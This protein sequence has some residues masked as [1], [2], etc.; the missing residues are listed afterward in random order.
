MNGSL[1]PDLAAMDLT[2][3]SVNNDYVTSISINPAYANGMYFRII[4]NPATIGWSGP[5]STIYLGIKATANGTIKLAC[6]SWSPGWGGS[7]DDKYLPYPC[8]QANVQAFLAAA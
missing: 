6:G 8:N 5:G 7:P 4:G 3:S 2:A 1:P